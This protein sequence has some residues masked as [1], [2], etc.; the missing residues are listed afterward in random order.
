VKPTDE[1]TDDGD[2]WPDGGTIDRDSKAPFEIYA[3]VDLSREERYHQRMD[4]SLIA[5][6]KVLWSDWRARVGV[7]IIAAYVLAGTVGVMVIES[8]STNT[9]N[10]MVPMFK[11]WDHVLGTD[12]SGRDLFALMVHGTP[13]ILKMILSGAIFAILAGAGVGMIAGYKGGLVDRALMVVTDVLMTLPG[14][15]LVIAISFVVEPESP[16]VIGLI[17]AINN[18]TGLA[19]AVRSQM[20]T[21]RDAG[22]VEVSRIMGISTP[23]I[24]KR[25][26]TPNLMPYILVNFMQASRRIIFESVGLYFLGILPINTPNWGVV[27]NLAYQQGALYSFGAIHWLL[28]PMMTV[29]VFSLG[30]IL[31]AQGADRVFNPRIRAKH[32]KTTG[33]GDAAN[34]RT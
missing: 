11:T 8:P 10:A 18:W 17:L 23:K 19:R 33:D 12:L 26:I 24:I 9:A 4:R 1:T 6:L 25:D 15:P 29:V 30:L 14:L 22:Y 16:Y 7:F 28:V 34:E 31:L 5:P 27:M 2:A 32:A 13:P 21:L 3:D 20:F